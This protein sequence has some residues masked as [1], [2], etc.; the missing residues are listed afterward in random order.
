MDASAIVQ[1]SAAVACL[2]GVSNFGHH[3]ALQNLS[4]SFSLLTYAVGYVVAT[5]LAYA[6]STSARTSTSTNLRRIGSSSM[7]WLGL[8]VVSAIA[9]NWLFLYVL[10]RARDAAH[11]VTALAFCAPVVTM[12]AVYAYR[13][14]TI[15]PLSTVA[16]LVTT[17]GAALAAYDMSHI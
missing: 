1:L 10:S 4:V 6:T 11:L 15:R 14:T 8:A 12:V 3:V 7:A 2:W 17:A 5:A 16:V 13:R 9:G